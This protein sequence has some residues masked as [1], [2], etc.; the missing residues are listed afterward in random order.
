MHSQHQVKIYIAALTRNYTFFADDY[1]KGRRKCDKVVNS[2]M[3]DLD[4]DSTDSGGKRKWV[5]MKTNV[6]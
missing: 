5:I 1:K 3:K 6:F 4:L 2:D